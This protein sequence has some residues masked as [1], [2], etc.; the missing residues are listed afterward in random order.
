MDKLTLPC[1]VIFNKNPTKVF[2]TGQSLRGY[3]RLTLEREQDV[4]SIAIRITGVAIAKWQHRRAIRRC[5]Q[6][7]LN[8]QMILIGLLNFRIFFRFITFF[9]NF[10]RM[11]LF[12]YTSI[13]RN[14]HALSSE[15]DDSSICTVFF[16]SSRNSVSLSIRLCDQ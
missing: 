1:D 6:D 3:V 11:F 5:K 10:R 12:D 13:R 2:Y 7:C 15:L 4:C 8:H 14:S 9:S 16:F